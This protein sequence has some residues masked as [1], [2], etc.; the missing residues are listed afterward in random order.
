MKILQYPHACLRQRCELV[1][2]SDKRLMDHVRALAGKMIELMHD[3]KGIGLSACQVGVP[4]RLFVMRIPREM[5][6]PLVFVNPVIE[7]VSAARVNLR[8][9][10]LSFRTVHDTIARPA[11]LMVSRHD[12]N[13]CYDRRHYGG[14]LAR[15]IHHE[16]DHLD[17]RLMIDH[18]SPSERTKTEKLMR[19]RHERRQ[20]KR[21]RS[22]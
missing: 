10:C 14:W 4:L 1:D 21:A 19:K 11:D 8:E 15:V 12:A 9:G 2:L 13:G 17:G 5:A 7:T 3:A 6:Q 22:I 20:A 16:I 18:M